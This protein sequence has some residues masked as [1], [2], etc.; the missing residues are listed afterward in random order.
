MTSGLGLKVSGWGVLGRKVS[1]FW[2]LE[3]DIQGFGVYG[4]DFRVWVSRASLIGVHLT[5]RDLEPQ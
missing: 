1:A 2:G 4:F 3:L 5:L